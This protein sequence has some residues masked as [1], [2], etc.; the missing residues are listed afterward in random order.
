MVLVL[1]FLTGKASTHF[2]KQ[3]E[4]TNKYLFPET[5]IRNGPRMSIYNLSKGAFPAL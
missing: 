5:E 4:T 3:S 2:V 1:K